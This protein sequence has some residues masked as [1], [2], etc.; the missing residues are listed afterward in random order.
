MHGLI[1]TS[2]IQKE[3]LSIISHSFGNFTLNETIILSRLLFFIILMHESGE[4]ELISLSMYSG[5]S[6]DEVAYARF[7]M[8]GGFD[9]DAIFNTGSLV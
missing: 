3:V 9:G 5:T 4:W 8:Q 2:C 7:E 1:N 6:L